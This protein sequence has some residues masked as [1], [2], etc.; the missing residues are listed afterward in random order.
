MEE[1]IKAYLN[2][3]GFGINGVMTKDPKM[4]G[5]R[6]EDYFPPFK[7]KIINYITSPSANTITYEF[8]KDGDNKFLAE[9]VVDPQSLRIMNLEVGENKK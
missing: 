9:Y 3:L 7:V 1:F 2:R 4:F 5:G 6:M 8:S